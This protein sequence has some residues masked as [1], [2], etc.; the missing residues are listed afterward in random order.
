MAGRAS[1]CG[2]YN[3]YTCADG[4][5]QN[6]GFYTLITTTLAETKSGYYVIGSCP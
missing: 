6:M 1:L 3:G 4:S 5:N 2:A